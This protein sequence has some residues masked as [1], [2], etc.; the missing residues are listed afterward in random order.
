MVAPLL[1]G[2]RYTAL[3]RTQG[4]LSPEEVRSC[5]NSLCSAELPVSLWLISRYCVWFVDRVSNSLGV[6][7]DKRSSVPENMKDILST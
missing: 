1:G 5:V 6:S 3:L 7:Q 2:R 4:L